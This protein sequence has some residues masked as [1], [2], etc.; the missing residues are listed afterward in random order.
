M[1]LCCQRQL[2]HTSLCTFV[3]IGVDTAAP[4][5]ALILCV[6]MFNGQKFSKLYASKLTL[7]VLQGK[8]VR[9]L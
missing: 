9:G 1:F 8:A 7:L 2:V 6:V 3:R 5:P 4:A